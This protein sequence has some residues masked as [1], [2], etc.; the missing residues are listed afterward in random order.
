MVGERRAAVM[1]RAILVAVA[2]LMT[3]TTGKAAEPVLLHAAGSLRAAMT[4]VAQA[5]EKA[6]GAPVTT[7]FGASGLL[8]DEIA[9]GY[10]EE[11]TTEF[12]LRVRGEMG[13]GVEGHTNGVH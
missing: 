3:A 2:G 4:E 12:G 1:I 10:T 11:S 7:K 5:F 6:G 8:R 9:G 13:V